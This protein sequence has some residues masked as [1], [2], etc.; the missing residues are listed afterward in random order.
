MAMGIYRR[1]AK[2]IDKSKTFPL[3]LQIASE[4]N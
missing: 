4:D 2:H 3:H 1:K